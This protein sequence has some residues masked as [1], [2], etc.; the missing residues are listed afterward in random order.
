MRGE[1]EICFLESGV[2]RAAHLRADAARIGMLLASADT[3]FLPFFQGQP[4]AGPE[5]L[6]MLP[7]DAEIVKAAKEPIFLGLV[8]GAARFALDYPQASAALPHGMGFADLRSIMASLDP[9]EA[10]LAATAKAILGWH[11]SHRFCSACGAPSLKS[12]AGWQ[13]VCPS[14]STTHFPRTDPVVIM[15]VTRGNQV[16]VGRSPGWPEGMFSLLAGFMEPGETIEAAV[17]REVAE[18]VGI[19]IGRVG[20]IASQP[21]PFPSSLMIGCWAEATSDRIDLDP[22]ELEAAMWMTREDM[23]AVFAGQ[24]TQMRPP[25]RGAIAAHLLWLW[26][27]DRV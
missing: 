5:G 23:A 27:A 21:W 10:E 19:S 15:L 6:G 9:R 12:M 20:Y 2:D 7:P 11:A 25:R 8:D 14:C 18:E 13:R 16:L 17:R 24:H 4:L 26:L 1:P 3:R 22:A